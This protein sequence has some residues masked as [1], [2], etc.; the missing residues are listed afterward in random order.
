MSRIE[1]KAPKHSAIPRVRIEPLREER[2]L[3]AFSAAQKKAAKRGRPL[4]FAEWIR[5]ALDAAA[6]RDLRS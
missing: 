1:T 2:Y 6:D 4:S 5:Q 3:S